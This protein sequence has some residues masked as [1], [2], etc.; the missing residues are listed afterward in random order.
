MQGPN[1]SAAQGAFD[2]GVDGKVFTT[3]NPEKRTYAS[4]AMPMTEAAIDAGFLRDVY[5]SLGE[6]L[7]G[8]GLGCAGVL[9]A[10]CGLDLG[11]CLIMAL[12]G[13]FRH[14]GPPPTACV[15]RH[16]LPKAAQQGASA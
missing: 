10:V 4:S 6:P 16:S 14:V 12:G 5:V 15:S 7:E 3:L 1:Y 8:K 2:V 13:L 9:Q 11:G